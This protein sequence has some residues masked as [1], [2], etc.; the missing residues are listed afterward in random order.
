M[1]FVIADAT[2]PTLARSF[3]NFGDIISKSVKERMGRWKVC[4]GKFLYIGI[5][6]V[7]KINKNSQPSLCAIKSKSPNPL[8]KHVSRNP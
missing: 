4:C 1:N 7:S 6:R 5:C 2:E 3:G 8:A